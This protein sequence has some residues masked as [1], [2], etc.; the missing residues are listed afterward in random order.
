MREARWANAAR[1]RAGQSDIACWAPYDRGAMESVFQRAR[2]HQIAG[3]LD[4]A[5]PLYLEAAGWKPE[6]TLGNL[7]VIYRVTGRLEEAKG[8]L[9][10]ALAVDP[11]NVPVR[12]TLG[13]TL[14]QLGEYAE[15]WR[16]YDARH[17]MTPPKGPRLPMWRGEP[18]AGRRIVVV[19]EQGLGDQILWS[20]YI[21]LLARQAAEV[22]VACPRTLGRLFSQLPVR[23]VHPTSWD[24]VVADLWCPLGS[25]PRWLGADIEGPPPSA[26]SSPTAA[27]PAAG[28]GLMLQGAPS[29]ANNANRLPGFGVARAIRGLADF[30]ELSPEAT[31]VGDFADTAR[32]VAGLE[33]VVTVD[34]SV[35]HLAGS[36]GKPCWV[37]M[38][39]PAIDWY[40]NWNDDRTPWYPS[41]RLLRQ[42]RAGDWAGVVADLAAGLAASS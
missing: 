11:G 23:V 12:H 41:V 37:L 38:S 18:L 10:R 25:V 6:W 40:T 33:A 14:L 28:F 24:E 31:G 36:M 1:R 34:T 19:A 13:M 20:R 3:R 4:E 15:G 26:L 7:G 9:R 16:H 17:E 32:I 39:R 35:A 30:V 27:Q 22:V 8:V 42:R 2:A 5:E 29:N 21:P